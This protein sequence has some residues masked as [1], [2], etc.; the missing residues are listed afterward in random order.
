[1]Q[2]ALVGRSSLV[3]GHRGL[4]GRVGYGE[5]EISFE[6]VIHRIELLAVLRFQFDRDRGKHQ[7]RRDRTAG[8]VAVRRDIH[9][10]AALL[11]RDRPADRDV[12]EHA[13][14]GERDDVGDVRARK[15][16]VAIKSKKRSDGEGRFAGRSLNR[17]SPR[18]GSA[19]QNANH[20]IGEVAA[21]AIGE[22]RVEVA[23]VREREPADA[24][25]KNA[26]LDVVLLIA[27]QRRGRTKEGR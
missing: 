9:R 23:G 22:V 1:M 6:K 25:T 27:I 10:D 19:D 5:A 13:V 24:K 4:A 2:Q 3:R 20:V 15:V 26:R 16:V 18:E 7:T 21:H 11:H 12:A 17:V 8:L 14:E